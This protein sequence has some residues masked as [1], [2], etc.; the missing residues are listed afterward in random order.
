[1]DG[2]D[3]TWEST[4]K[5]NSDMLQLALESLQEAER[6]IG[7]PNGRQAFEIALL[8]IQFA[9]AIE[10]RRISLALKEVGK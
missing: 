9:Q 10:L 6:E 8:R 5:L 1:M 4:P 7:L 2:D 3:M